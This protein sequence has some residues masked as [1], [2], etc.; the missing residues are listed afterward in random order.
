MRRKAG[1]GWRGLIRGWHQLEAWRGRIVSK[2][3]SIWGSRNR[4]MDEACNLHPGSRDRDQVG[5][6]SPTVFFTS[7]RDVRICHL[8]C[9]QPH[10]RILSVVARPE[11]LSVRVCW[12]NC[13]ILYF[14]SP[15]SFHTRTPV[16]ITKTRRS[17]DRAIGDDNKQYGQCGE[18]TTVVVADARYK[19]IW[20]RWSHLF[21]RTSPGHRYR[22]LLLL[23]LVQT[24][25][26]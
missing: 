9:G 8:Q 11:V 10:L 3:A 24:N 12:S 2:Y 4:K 25:I 17:S 14:H 22:L 18:I 13:F 7:Q 21:Q 6:S 15:R 20:S 23:L 5:L 19:D 1:G 26:A 16:S